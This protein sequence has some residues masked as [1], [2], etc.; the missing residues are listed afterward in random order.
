MRIK[1]KAFFVS[2]NFWRFS[3]PDR[4]NYLI[5]SDKEFQFKENEDGLQTYRSRHEALWS[6]SGLA[7]SSQ[8]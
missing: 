4:S 8:W 3:L 6:P 5:L 1:K 2:I 7:T